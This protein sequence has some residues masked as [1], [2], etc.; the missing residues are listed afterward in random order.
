MQFAWSSSCKALPALVLQPRSVKVF[1]H[2]LTS[3]FSSADSSLALVEVGALLAVVK[4][5]ERVG[6]RMMRD[7]WM[8]MMMIVYLKI[9]LDCYCGQDGEKRYNTWEKMIEE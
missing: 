2:G 3:R 4:S 9:F 5:W 6:R 8:Y 7:W 1:I